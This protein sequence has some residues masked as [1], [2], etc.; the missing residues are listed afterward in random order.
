MYVQLTLRVSS[1]QRWDWH[2]WFGLGLHCV[3]FIFVLNYRFL[4]RAGLYERPNK[5]GATSIQNATLRQIV[6]LDDEHFAPLCGG[7]TASEYQ[8]FQRLL[9]L[10]RLEEDEDD[11]E[12]ELEEE[13]SESL[14]NR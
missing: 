6:D 7:M 10:E 3:R 14:E 13:D 5:H 2:P 11:E 8:T 1:I 9:E 12:G 4:E